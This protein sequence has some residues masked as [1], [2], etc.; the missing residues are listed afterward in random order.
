MADTLRLV[1][2]YTSF[3]DVDFTASTEDSEFPATNL[4]D[5]LRSKVWRTTSVSSQSVIVDLQSQEEADSFAVFFR[6]NQPVKLT[7]G[8]TIKVEGNASA[9]FTSPLFSTTVTLDTDNLVISHFLTSSESHRYWRLFIDDP[10]NP[11][12]HL[13][14]S[15]FVVGKSE[16]FTGVTR[17]FKWSNIDASKTQRTAFG[18]MYSDVLPVRK[19]FEFELP[20]EDFS[21]FE[22]AINFYGLVGKTEGFLTALDPEEAIWGEKDR[23]LLWGNFSSDFEAVDNPSVYFTMPFAVEEQL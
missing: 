22:R 19:R 10:G 14:V 12:G 23:F 1:R 2:D 21:N 13:E 3:S 17:G 16:K 9:D 11:Y 5:Q 7:G 20:L 8:A 18:Q 6:A 15:K 4:A